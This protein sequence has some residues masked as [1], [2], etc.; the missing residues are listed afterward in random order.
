MDLETYCDGVAT[1]AV[2]IGANVQH[3]QIVVIT[4]A[5]G[6]E[7]LAHAIARKAYERDAKFVE[8]FVFDGQVKRIR[9]ETA[10]EETLEFVPDWWS[11]RVLALG[12]V[13]AARISIAPNPDPGVLEGIDPERA[14]KDDLPFV[15]EAVT[16]IK[17]RS[18]NWTIVAYPTPG[19][20]AKV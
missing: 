2:E 7:P 11:Q 3:D 13:K 1:L 12:E 5:P 16:L 19:W 4:Y 15:K 14:G 8:P 17:D 10:R 9:L 18:T 6:M 20:A